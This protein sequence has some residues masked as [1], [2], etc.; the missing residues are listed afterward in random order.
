M[1]TINKILFISVSLVLG[2][3]TSCSE[4]IPS[5]EDSPVVSE[6]TVNAFFPK[7][8]SSTFSVGVDATK[9]TLSLSRVKTDT[10]A[11]VKLSKTMHIKEV[12][13]LRDSVSFAAGESTAQIEVAFSNLDK[14]KTY[15]LGLRLDEKASDPYEINELGTT[16][17]VVN[18]QQE[19]WTDYAQGT[20][21]SGFLEDSWSQS[22]QYSALLDQYRFP[23]VWANGYHLVFTWDKASNVK[24]VEDAVTTGYV[25]SKYGMVTYS[26]ITS[27]WTYN[28]TT[29]TFH[30]LG[31]WTVSAGSF[32]EAEET[33]TLN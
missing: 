9:F 11:K 4:D 22:L 32:G 23:N 26:P 8:Q 25:H 18:I 33:F 13:V 6:G 16:N 15:T 29:K 10:S 28:S 20:F 30:L 24:P 14:F 17:F 1:K 5:R 31:E 19:D 21:T 2:V 7:A 12:F 27:D 3:L